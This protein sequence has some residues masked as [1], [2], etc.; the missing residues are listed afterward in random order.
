MSHVL[1]NMWKGRREVVAL[2]TKYYPVRGGGYQS[3]GSFNLLNT[4]EPYTREHVAYVT[5]STTKS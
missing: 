3:S 2:Q 5:F 4:L 1:P